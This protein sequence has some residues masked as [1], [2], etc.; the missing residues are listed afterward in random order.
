MITHVANAN[1][2][3]KTGNSLCMIL[4]VNIQYLVSVWVF[5]GTL[6]Y[7]ASTS[8]S[9]LSQ[10]TVFSHEQVCRYLL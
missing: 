10:Q 7:L 1:V 4:N 3:G 6:V 9:V 8:F 5:L 2:Y